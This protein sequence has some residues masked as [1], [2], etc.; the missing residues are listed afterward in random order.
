MILNYGRFFL[1]AAPSGEDMVLQYIPYQELVRQSIFQGELPFWNPMTFCGRPLMADIQVGVL[2]GPNWLHWFL[3]L[4]VSFTLLLIAHAAWG[5]WG[6]YRLGR[7]WELS[8][9]AASLMGVLYVFSGFL[10]VKLQS[11]GVLF[12]YVAVWLP[13]QALALNALFRNPS[14]KRAAILALTLSMALL[15]GSP[16]MTFYSWIILAG[17]AV[18]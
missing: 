15:A 11:G 1:G 12:H 17:L 4:P 18:V 3:P 9:P 5:L 13:W 6:C 7:A 16:Q 14:P 10:T 8:T 2:Y